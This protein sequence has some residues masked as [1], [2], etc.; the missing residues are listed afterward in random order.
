[1]PSSVAVYFIDEGYLLPALVSAIQA[2]E[3]S[4]R[5]L[6][7][8]VIVCAGAVTEKSRKASAVAAKHGVEILLVPET[9]LEGMP[10]YFGRLNL[11][12]VLPEQYER[13]I[14]IDGDT[15]IAAALDPLAQAPLE[16]GQLLAARDPAHMFRQLSRRWQ[17][18]I[19]AD[20]RRGGF[21]G[22]IERYFNSGVLV[23]LRN[24]WPELVAKT[25]A[26]YNAHADT[27]YPDQDILNRALDGHCIRIS[28]RWNFPGFL[29]GS[30]MEA[31]TRPVIYHFMS[32]PRP[33]NEA[34][35]PWGKR[36]MEPYDRLLRE[37]PELGFLAPKRP[38][39]TH[40]KH[41][42]QQRYKCLAEYNRVGRLHEV[43][44]EL[45]I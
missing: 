28:N 41:V 7:D 1:M 42:L 24:G 17:Q 9:F 2:R 21:A 19:D 20:Y 14:Y 27:L 15:Q 4:S 3:H 29:I 40:V 39:V 38:I 45:D 37:H 5:E 13:I 34:V 18:T 11:H 44:P 22:E 30:P 43:P 6:I 25:L 23:I 35:K 31:A 8:V 16:P 10:A 12:K 33:W 36:W 26:L 32:N